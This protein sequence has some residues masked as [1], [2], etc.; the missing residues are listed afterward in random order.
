M[1]YAKTGAFGHVGVAITFGLVIMVMIYSVGH[2]S[3][4]GF[5]GAD[6]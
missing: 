6:P 1:V 4:A 3:G 2:I 5:N